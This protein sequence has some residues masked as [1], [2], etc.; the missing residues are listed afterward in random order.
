M[1]YPFLQANRK[2]IMKIWREEGKEVG[3]EKNKNIM[4][5]EILRQFF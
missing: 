4:K 2:E 5:N 1:M 3:D